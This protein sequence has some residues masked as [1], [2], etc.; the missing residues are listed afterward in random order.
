MALTRPR[1]GQLNTNVVAAADP[2]QVLHAG[3]NAANVDIGFLMN[4]ANGLVSN[5]ALYWNESGN[6]FVTAFTA[7]TGSTDTNIAATSYAPITTGA[8][9]IAG[10]IVKTTVY[11]KSYY[12]RKATGQCILNSGKVSNLFVCACCTL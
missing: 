11:V 9:T 12:N 6:T 8:H 4:R 2:I 7:N 5:V 10:N 3:S 1:L